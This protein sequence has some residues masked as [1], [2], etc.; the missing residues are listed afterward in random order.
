MNRVKSSKIAFELMRMLI[1][2]RRKPL[3]VS[4]QLTQRCNLRCKYCDYHQGSAQDELTTAQIIRI[5]DQLKAAGTLAISFTGGEP[6]IRDDIGEVIAYTHS[7]GIIA[8]INTNGILVPKK[9]KELAHAGQVNLSFDGRES[10]HDRVRGK[11]SYAALVDAIELLKHKA[12]SIAFHATL[13]DCSIDNTD[14]ILD[15]CSQWGIGVFFQPATELFI[16]NRDSNPYAPPRE[17]YRRA[18]FYLL[19]KKKR[20]CKQIL[21]SAA[22]IRHLANWPSAKAIYCSA[23]KIIFRINAYGELYHCDRFPLK[24]KLDLKKTCLKDALKK[25]KPL[26]C[27]QCWCAPLVELNLAM[28]F[29]F[30]S[31]IN[32]FNSGSLQG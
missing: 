24:N 19:Q 28:G 21:N 18:M 3:F 7:K 10:T 20:G 32:A 26:S 8:K 6:L 15:S 14:F 29:N 4:W 23:G 16:L 5:I 12:K 9:I 22:G 1:L 2:G 25:I 27:R 13:T 31:I 30:N 17:E 11:G